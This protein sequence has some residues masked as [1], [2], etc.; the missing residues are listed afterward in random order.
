MTRAR[1]VALAAVLLLAAVVGHA[2]GPRYKDRRVV[3]VLRE[4]QKQGMR[5]VFSTALVRPEMRVAAEP[6][7]DGDR[8]KVI[9]AILVPHGLMPRVGPRGVLLIVRAPRLPH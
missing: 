7:D 8:R 5:I 4:F 6:V 9:T 3:D 2:A 1:V